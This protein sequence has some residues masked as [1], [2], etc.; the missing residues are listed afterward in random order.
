MP[1]PDLS[2]PSRVTG[3]R[4]AC[5]ELLIGISTAKAQE[6]LTRAVVGHMTRA[7]LLRTVLELA[8]PP[9]APDGIFETGGVLQ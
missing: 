4:R 1:T 5:F 8:A 3:L 9:F 7:L 2:L 6:D